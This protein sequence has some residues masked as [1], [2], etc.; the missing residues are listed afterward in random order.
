MEFH[1]TLMGKKFYDGDLPRLIESIN[2]LTAALEKSNALKEKSIKEN[3]AQ[4]VKNRLKV[5]ESNTNS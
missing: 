2:R 4:A 1:K 5:S 3:K